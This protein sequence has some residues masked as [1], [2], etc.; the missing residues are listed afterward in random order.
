MLIGIDLVD[1]NRIKAAIERTPRFLERVFTPAEREYCQRKTNPYPSLAVRFAAKE[2]VRKLGEE[3]SKGIQFHDIEI[4]N[5]AAGRPY[6]LLHGL[7]WQRS[8]EGRITMDVS[9]SHSR[10]QAIAT[11]IATRGVLE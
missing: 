8:Q 5:D 2:A 4:K 7:A 3:Y 9:L 6:I 10:N 11:V 1:I